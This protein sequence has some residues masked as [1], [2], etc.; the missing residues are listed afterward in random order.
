MSALITRRRL[1]LAG[2]ALLAPGMTTQRAEAADDTALRVRPLLPRPLRL[3]VA[4][5]PG[6]VSATLAHVLAE[7]LAGPLGVQVIVDYRAGDGG[8]VAMGMIARAAPDGT[9]LV[10]SAITPLTVRPLVGA[11]TYDPL[12]DIAPVAGVMHTPLL[13]VGTPALPYDTLADTL[14]HARA[15]PGQLR[16]ASSGIAT[17]GHLV[18]EQVSRASGTRIVHVP[19]K[20]GGQQIS[21]ALGG[22]F[23]LLSTNVS[24]MQLRAIAAG[25]FKP[26]AVGAPARLPVLPDVPTFAE[27]GFAQANLSS[28]F[29]V[30]APGGTPVALLSVLNRAIN[31][32]VTSATFQQRLA[33]TDNLPATDTRE[34]FVARI[35]ADF[36]ANRAMLRAAPLRAP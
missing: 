19:Y 1:V 4:Y 14:R 27:L 24:E 31:T 9:T 13:L 25:Q 20:G 5:P 10:F 30:F 35:R 32:A 29:G 36:D 3:V 6:G 12:R 7:E 34:A 23:E 16:W 17:T 15:H 18:M 28:L 21:D 11:V 8:S 2:A 26:L 22:Q 33:V